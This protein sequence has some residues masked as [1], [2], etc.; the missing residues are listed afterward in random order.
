M[1]ATRWLACY[2]FRLRFRQT[3]GEQVSPEYQ[4]AKIELDHQGVAP[5]WSAQ[6]AEYN[7][8][9]PCLQLEKC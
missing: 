5:E 9:T 6:R 1:P 3:A 8:Q 7:H 4:Q 2:A